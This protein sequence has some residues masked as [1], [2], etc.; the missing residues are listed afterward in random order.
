MD[1]PEVTYGYYGG[2]YGGALDEDG[3]KLALP[4]AASR[5]RAMVWPRD[6]WG[7]EDAYRRAVCAVCDVDAAWGYSGGSGALSSV[8]AGNVSM[9]FA[10][11]DGSAAYDADARRAAS[12]EL[13]GSGLLFMGLGD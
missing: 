11:G 7:D 5:V 8:S 12:A 10:G 13:T 2:T 6:P 1:A 4:H 3:F 9:S